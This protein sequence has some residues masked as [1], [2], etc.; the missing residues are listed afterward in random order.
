MLVM[1][2]LRWA[3]TRGH[4]AGTWCSDN[5]LWCVVHTEETCIESVAGTCSREKI[6][7]FAHKWKFGAGKGKER[8]YVWVSSRSSA[9]APNYGHCKLK[10]IINT[11]QVK[12]WFLRRAETGAPGEN[13][14]VQSR[15]PTNSNHTGTCF[16]DMLQRH[17]PA[18][19]PMKFNLLNFV[20]HVAGTRLPPNSCCTIIKVSVHTGG[21]VPETC[22][23]NIF[24]CARV[25]IC[26]FCMSPPHVPATCRLSVH[27]TC[28]LS[29]QHDLSCLPTFTDF[30]P[31]I[32]NVAIHY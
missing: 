20:R 10:L 32:K 27:Y 6:T 16:R 23:P 2:H 3:D 30:L 26:P 14:S 15:E 7:I 28:F 25:A 13:L 4:V 19:C 24:V 1:R 11:N 31:W 12:C 5:N 21:H 29:L 9:G 8:N 22:T 17:V 18:T